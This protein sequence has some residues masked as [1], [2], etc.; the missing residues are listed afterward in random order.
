MNLPLL[1]FSLQEERLASKTSNAVICRA[2]YLWSK[3]CQW[4]GEFILIDHQR[5]ECLKVRGCFST[6]CSSMRR[7]RKLR[8]GSWC[9]YR[10]ICLFVCMCRSQMRGRR[11]V[12][13]Q[14][15]PVEMVSG[16]RTPT[17]RSRG[18]ALSGGTIPWL[19]TYRTQR[20]GQRMFKCE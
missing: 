1:L 5:D 9:I 13:N 3:E 6:P 2:C 10:N 11:C 17:P 19:R 15:Q 20:A 16:C 14:K 12:S 4:F 7:T 8:K 18:Y